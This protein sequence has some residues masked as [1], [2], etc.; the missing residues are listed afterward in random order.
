MRFNKIIVGTCV[1]LVLT[2]G[3]AVGSL[4]VSA[5]AQSAQTAETVSVAVG[6]QYD[7]THVY[8]APG[9]FRSLRRE[10]DCDIWRHN[11]QAGSLHSNSDPEQHHVATGPDTR[12]LG[13]GFRL[14]DADPVSVWLGAYR[15]SGHGHGRSGPRRQGHWRRRLRRSLQ[16]SDRSRR[17]HSMARWCEHAIVLA[18]HCAV[19]YPAPDNPGE[20]GLCVTGQSGCLRAQLS[21]VLPWNRRV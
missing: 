12:G 6:P 10:L 5:F 17:D 15:L 14:Q 20:S 16:R 9:R 13:I 8:V 21:C 19:L 11:D 7:T 2:L 18:H 1:A 4:H 3:L